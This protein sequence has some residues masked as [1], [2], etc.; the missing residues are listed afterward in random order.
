MLGYFFQKN[1]AKKASL[2][3]TCCYN[4]LF[5]DIDNSWVNKGSELELIK[6]KV[7]QMRVLYK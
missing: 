6:G 1:I 2:R 3:E 5:Q 7:R 4:E